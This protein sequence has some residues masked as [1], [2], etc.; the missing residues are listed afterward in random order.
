ML[1]M[2]PEL[3][4]AMEINHFQAHLMKEALHR[5]RNINATNNRIVEDVLIVF[6]WKYVK[7]E[8]RAAAEQKYQRLTIDPNTK[9]ISDFLEES[10]EYAERAFAYNAQQMINSFLYAELP[11]HL[12]LSNNLA[13][14]EKR[15]VGPDG[16]SSGKST[17]ISW[18]RIR[19]RTPH[20]DS[21]GIKEQRKKTVFPKTS[22]LCCKKLGHL[23][24]DCRR[25]VRKEQEQ[26][27]YP[28]HKVEIFT[29]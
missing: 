16:S 23:T 9:C 15:H 14:L 26:K 10:S 6:R 11:P 22:Y 18:H 5:F 25:K 29:P 7:F 4:E 24:K 2:Q 17:R 28:T 13:Y 27:Q 19:R 21:N 12:K 20:N 3:T 8:S 1:K